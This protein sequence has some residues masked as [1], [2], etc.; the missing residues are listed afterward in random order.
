MLSYSP[1]LNVA[2]IR[3]EESWARNINTEIMWTCITKEEAK[4]EPGT[5][6]TVLRPLRVRNWGK[7]TAYSYRLYNILTDINKSPYC[8]ALQRN[9]KTICTSQVEGVGE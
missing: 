5:K 8:K 1:S 2:S 6:S 3:K 7:H 4:R 9:D